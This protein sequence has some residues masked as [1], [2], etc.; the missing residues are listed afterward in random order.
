[1][2]LLATEV[3]PSSESAFHFKR[4]IRS[5]SF[6]VRSTRVATPV[7]PEDKA[8]KAEDVPGRLKQAPV[9]HAYV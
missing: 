7:F 9:M 4:R 5:S 3:T 2:S 1:M 6:A 8:S